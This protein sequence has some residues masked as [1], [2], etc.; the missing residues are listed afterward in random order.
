MDTM[1]LILGTMTFGPQVD[2]DGARTMMER[3]LRAGHHELDAAYVYNNGETERMLGTLLTGSSKETFSIATKVHPRITGRL[4]RAAVLAQFDESLRRLNRDAVD[5][6][7]FHMPDRRTPIEDALETCA[8]LHRQG[9]FKELGLSNFPAWMVVDIWHL[10]K[11]RGWPQPT[12]YQGLYNGLSRKVEDELFPA[13][14]R[15][16]MRFY[17]YNPLAG[18]MLSGKHV[19]YDD[20]PPLG[21]FGRLESYRN[22]YWKKSYFE[23]VSALVASCRDV[24]IAPAEAAFRWLAHHSLLDRRAGD[25]IIVGA[26]DMDQLEQNLTAAEQGALPETVVS[27]FDAA[28]VEAEPESPG[29][30]RYYS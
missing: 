11:D 3:F 7:Y 12:V 23:A 14:R 2:M 16:G 10:C 21:R 1:R 26:S 27:A 13:L 30:F 5:L 17:A 22:R 6:L 20:V 18:G 8:A 28:W 25:G 9:K 29:Y 4:D 24:G 19:N 15:L